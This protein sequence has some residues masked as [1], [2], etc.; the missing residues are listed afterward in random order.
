[1]LQKYKYMLKNENTW[2][3]STDT[4]MLQGTKIHVTKVKFM[5]QSRK[6]QVLSSCLVRRQQSGW[7]S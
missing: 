1:M 2:Y 5:L 3:K 6:F 7:K 4:Y